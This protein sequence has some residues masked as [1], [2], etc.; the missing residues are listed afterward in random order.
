[1]KE[2]KL[3]KCRLGDRTVRFELRPCTLHMGKYKQ[4]N[5][6][7]DHTLLT[8]QPEIEDGLFER[9]ILLSHGL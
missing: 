6:H 9:S 4:V 3:D 1:M 2:E 8:L 7:T 5:T